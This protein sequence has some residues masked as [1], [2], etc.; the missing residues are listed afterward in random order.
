MD[1]RGKRKEILTK[2]LVVGEGGE[3]KKESFHFL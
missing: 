1:G 3:K 2:K